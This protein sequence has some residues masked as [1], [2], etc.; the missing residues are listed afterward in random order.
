M[1]VLV[2]AYQAAELAG[3]HER[4][5][6]RHIHTGTLPAKKVG[7]AYRID[8]DDLLKLPGGAN[9]TQPEVP[10][11]GPRLLP[12]LT[13]T[14]TWR[15][16]VALRL[17]CRSWC[18]LVTAGIVL[19]S[20]VATALRLA[21]YPVPDE[22]QWPVSHHLGLIIATNT[23][24]FDLMLIIGVANGTFEDWIAAVRNLASHLRRGKGDR[25]QNRPPRVR[26]SVRERQER[27][28]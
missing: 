12:F 27:A 24:A 7:R 16:P 14:R 9:I 20:L 5:L 19:A 23:L 18:W 6:R 28:A 8:V 26:W 17:S 2:N 13:P 11:V 3:I 1:G 21:L 10:A 4:N 25:Q 15:P 22:A